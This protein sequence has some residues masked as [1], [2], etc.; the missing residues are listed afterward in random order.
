MCVTKIM[1]PVVGH[2]R[3][4][5]FLSIIYLDDLLLIGNSYSKRLENIKTSIYL[6]T[7]LGF[8]INEEKSYKLS[9]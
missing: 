8:I 3:N 1:K 2:L 7:S 4:Q 6:L 9:S 5:G